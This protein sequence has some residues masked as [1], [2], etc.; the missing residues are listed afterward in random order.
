M[1]VSTERWGFRIEQS[2]MVCRPPGAPERGWE[3]AHGQQVLAADGPIKPGRA[4]VWVRA[5]RPP[6]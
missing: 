2:H 5:H 6:Y 3:I 4:V 1:N